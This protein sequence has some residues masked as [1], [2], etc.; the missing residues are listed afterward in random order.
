M[1]PQ[2][3]LNDL[4]CYIK[5]TK[6]QAEKR[7]LLESF[8]SERNKCLYLDADSILFKVAH[9]HVEEQDFEV[10]YEDYHTQVREIVNRIEEEGFVI[11]YV[12]HF[13]TTCS[14][15]FRYEVDENYKANREKTPLT[16]IVKHFK[17]YVISVL[18]AEGELTKYSDTLEADD[19]IAW[20]VELNQEHY[21]IVASIDKDLRQIPAC[22]FNYYKY[23]VKD[24]N[25]EYIIE[26]YIDD[27]GDVKER[28]VTD[29]RGFSY[30]T[31]QEGYEM[32]LEMLLVGDTSDNIKGVKG[33][34]KVKAKKLLNERN[35]FGKLRAVVEAYGDSKRLRNNIK[36]MKL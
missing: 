11:D 2:E 3:E 12:T 28:F 29:F 25:G 17:W 24:G 34:G 32:L 36:L 5:L 31:P 26:T 23:K 35:N 19:L 9:Y 22:H 10:M 6:E 4:R 33:I 7:D 18:E 1:T 14:N 16:E 15:N 8:L 21:P 27:N 20:A 13:F 30:T